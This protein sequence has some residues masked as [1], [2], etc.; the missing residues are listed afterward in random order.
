MG[1]ISSTGEHAVATANGSL[2]SRACWAD[3]TSKFASD[4]IQMMLKKMRI[5]EVPMES[6]ELHPLEDP[7]LFG[8]SPWKIAATTYEQMGS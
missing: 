4:F 8:P 7:R 1:R 6:Q 5:G 2:K 3:V